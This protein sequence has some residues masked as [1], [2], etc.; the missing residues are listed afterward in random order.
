MTDQR[1]QFDAVV[2]DHTFGTSEGS[3]NHLNAEQ[4]REQVA[5]FRAGGLMAKDARVVAHHLAH[6][7]NPSHPELVEFAASHSYEVAFDGLALEI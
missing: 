7:S 4:F 1:W 2:L 6:H 3:A 5:P